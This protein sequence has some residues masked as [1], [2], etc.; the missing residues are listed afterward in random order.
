MLLI[1]FKNVS[2]I[3]ISVW[4]KIKNGDFRTRFRQNERSY[5]SE[6]NSEVLKIMNVLFELFEKMLPESTFGG[7]HR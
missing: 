6:Y 7:S 4:I 5:S 3:E 2:I 1:F